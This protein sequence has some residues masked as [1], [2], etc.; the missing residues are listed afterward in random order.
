L[1]QETDGKISIGLE[2]FGLFLPVGNTMPPWDGFLQPPSPLI[3]FGFT[4]NSWAGAG[5]DKR[6]ILIFGETH[7]PVGFIY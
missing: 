5:P 4:I 2:V 1:T 6:I 3:R 7:L